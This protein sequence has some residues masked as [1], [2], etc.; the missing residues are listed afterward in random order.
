[1]K[2]T[3]ACEKCGSCE[4]VCPVQAIS[5]KGSKMEIDQS[6]CLECGAC[7]AQC[8]LGAIEEE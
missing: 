5:E 3:D 1:M 2:I 7:L 8:P 4:I 6:I